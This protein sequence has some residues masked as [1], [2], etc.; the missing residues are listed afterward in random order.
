MIIS[1]PQ[2]VHNN[3]MRDEDSKAMACCLVISYWAYFID[4][5]IIIII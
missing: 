5:I 1:R 4:L 3:K 2:L